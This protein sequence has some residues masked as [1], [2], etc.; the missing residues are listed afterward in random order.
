MPDQLRQ[1]LADFGTNDDFVVI[2]AEGIRDD[3]SVRQFVIEAIRTIET[4]RVSF[5]GL[6]RHPG[7]CRDDGARVNSAAQEC[8]QRYIAYHPNTDGFEQFFAHT[9]DPFAFGPNF[10]RASWHVPIL[11]VPNTSL[12]NNHQMSGE[13]FLDA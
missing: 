9:L 3:S 11:L 5:D 1:Q 6:I 12:L 2:R 4:Y 7:H 10:D 13:Q 8:A